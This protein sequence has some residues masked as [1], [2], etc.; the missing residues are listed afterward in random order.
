MNTQFLDL[1]KGPIPCVVTLSNFLNKNLELT[2]QGL[3][4]ILLAEE[5][6][7]EEICTDTS[8]KK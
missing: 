7:N 3:E 1:F 5:M 8:Q 6:L 2:E 4:I